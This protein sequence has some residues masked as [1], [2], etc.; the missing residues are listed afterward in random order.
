[1]D[2]ASDEATGAPSAAGAK[3][4]GETLAA[5]VAALG[6]EGRVVVRPTDDGGLVGLVEAD[7]VG[8]LIGR[9]GQVIDAIQYLA[10]QI[11]SRAEGGVR[12]RV[13]VDAGG[14]RARRAEQLE[15]LAAR[16]AEEAL[17]DGDE[18]ELDPMTPHDR[19][20]V[21]LALEDHPGVV[22]RSEGDEPQRR[23]IV[24]PAEEPSSD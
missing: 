22:T 11:V 10:V 5:V 19:R 7:D 12:S 4:L 23:I 14:Y 9:D 24:E 3:A 8:G 16:A 18:I 17:R 13:V 2:E 20:I 15:R 1:V 21:H 6:I